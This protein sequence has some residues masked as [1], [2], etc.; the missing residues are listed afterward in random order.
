MGSRTEVHLSLYLTNIIV[1]VTCC[2]VFGVKKNWAAKNMFTNVF[3]FNPRSNGL[4]C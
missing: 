1:L 2:L 3:L 4:N